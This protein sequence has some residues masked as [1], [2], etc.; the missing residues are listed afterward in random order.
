MKYAT[1]LIAAAVGAQA[2]SSKNGTQVVT[3]VVDQYVTYCPGPTHITHGD[4]VYTVTKPTTLTIT[5]CPCTIT[6]PVVSTS[7]VVCHT[8]TAAPSNP[9]ATEPAATEPAA[10]EPAATVPA[11][12]GGLVMTPTKGQPTTVPTAGAGKAAALSGAGLAGI[13]GLAAFVL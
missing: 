9:A 5:N 11:P 3:E 13:V 10:T 1:A 12:T 7:A 8:C 2:W 6:R 4:K